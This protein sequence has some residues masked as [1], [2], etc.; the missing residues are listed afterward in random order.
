MAGG[1]GVNRRDARS[2][3]WSR[4]LVITAA[5]PLVLSAA[6]CSAGAEQA[7]ATRPLPPAQLTIT[8]ANGTQNARPG[9]G[10]MVTAANGKVR[11]VVVR[12]ADGVVAGQLSGDGTVWRSSGTL[13]P[14]HRYTVTATAVGAARKTVTAT[15]SFSTLRPKKTF[16]ASITEGSGREYGVGMPVILTFSRPITRKA[17]VER[18]LSLNTS[19][20]VV[21]AWYWDGGKT[22]VFRPRAY[23]PAHTRVTVNGHFSGVEGARGVYGTRDLH[24]TFEN[25]RS[26]IVVASTRT[27]Y[28]RVYYQGRLFARWPIS[29]GRPGDDTANGTYVTIDKGNPLFFTGPGYALWVPWAVRITWSGTYIHDAYWSVWAQGSVNVSHGCINTSPVHAETY[30][31]M[32]VPGDPVTVTGSPRSGTWDNGWTEWFLSWRQLLKGSAL[33]EAVVAGPDGSSSCQPRLA[34]PGAGICT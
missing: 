26:L 28:M 12:T 18:S 14:A 4:H 34:S 20:P 29:T 10:V 1:F 22:L 5:T 7:A 25:G 16:T 32:E 2:G 33:H 19:K 27:H 24:Q 6:A 13:D 21:G 31:K 23:W 8:P 30:Y 3:G 17:A 9:A 11:N 15:G